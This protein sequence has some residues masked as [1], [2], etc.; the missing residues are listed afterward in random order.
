MARF[1]YG[2]NERY[3]FPFAVGYYCIFF[4]LSNAFIIAIYNFG[5]SN[6]LPREKGTCITTLLYYV[7]GPRQI[8]NFN[9]H[10]KWHVISKILNVKCKFIY[11]V[12]YNLRNL[13]QNTNLLICFLRS[14]Q[15]LLKSFFL[16]RHARLMV[17]IYCITSHNIIDACNVVIVTSF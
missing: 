17:T 1:S 16:F 5:I 10:V 11:S 9:M 15:L 12:L 6:G 14:V 13:Y 8:V 4:F 7:H 3:V 2:P